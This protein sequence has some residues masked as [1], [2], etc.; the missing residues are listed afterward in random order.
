MEDG[1]LGC[2]RI[3]E[4]WGLTVEIG[5]HAFN[6]VGYLAGTDEERLADLNDALR[7]PRVRAIF[8]TRGGKGSYR[9]A[10]RLDFYAAARD[11]K[12]LIGFSDITALHLAL[13]RA[14]GLVGIHGPL[15]S[16]SDEFVGPE[17]VE[18]LRRALMTNDPIVLCADPLEA[19]SSLTTSGQASGI[20]IGG[21]LDTLAISAGWALPSVEGAI[22]LIEASNMGLGHVDRQLTMLAN[23]GHLKGLHGVAVGQFTDFKPHG[24]LTI[25]DVLRDRLGRHGVPIL[26]GLPIGH[27]KHPKTV[28]IGTMATL[29]AKRGTLTVMA[30]TRPAAT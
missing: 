15:A 21:N 12:F 14:C 9:I 16:W 20:L 10:D 8:A 26:G 11:P 18:S 6:E 25:I 28:P 30:G 17:S 23:A 19:T 7:D 5:K 29:D 1:V 22:L 2:A 24:D 27:G 4:S 13:F 3:F